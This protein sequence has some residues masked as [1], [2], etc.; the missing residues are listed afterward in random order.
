MSNGDSSS[1]FRHPLVVSTVGIAL[2]ALVTLM[3]VPRLTR[4]WQDRPRELELKGALVQQAAESATTTVNA[5]RALARS[6]TA[7]RPGSPVYVQTKGAWLVASGVVAAELATYFP[8]APETA[9]ANYTS[10]VADY[11]FLSAGR[12]TNERRVAVLRLKTYL[13][14]VARDS[15]SRASFL[16]R[17]IRWELLAGE[18]GTARFISDFDELGELLVI[19]GETVNRQLIGARARGFSHGF[20]IFR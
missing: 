4:V 13:A 7:A 5:S 8:G 2:S 17:D 3:L 10:R 11:L 12:K 14:P 1:V 18:R 16:F 20:W 15:A 9:W 6:P 19:Q